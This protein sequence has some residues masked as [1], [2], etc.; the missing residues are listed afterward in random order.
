[1]M[2]LR[3]YC[4]ALKVRGSRKCIG[5]YG[6]TLLPQADQDV[7][8]RLSKNGNAN[9]APYFLSDSVEWHWARIVQPNL[10]L[11]NADNHT[12]HS[13]VFIVFI[14]MELSH[15]AVHK[16]ARSCI[17]PEAVSL[18]I[19]KGSIDCMTILPGPFPNGW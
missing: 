15:V 17:D 2:C 7:S 6:P 9:T 19:T 11:P 10:K 12:L 18:N 5:P 3:G 14:S 13:I 8:W 4:V 1:M 16:R